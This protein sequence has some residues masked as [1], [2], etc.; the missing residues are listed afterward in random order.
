VIFKSGL[1]HLHGTAAN[2][3]SS[4][5]PPCDLTT[6]RAA[7]ETTNSLQAI[8]S[9]TWPPITQPGGQ[10]IVRPPRRCRWIWN[11]V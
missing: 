3:Q 10:C 1:R 11:T 4:P 9:S 8:E 2:H 7:M 6:D 5:R